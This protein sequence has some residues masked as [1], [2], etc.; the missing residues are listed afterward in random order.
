MLVARFPKDHPTPKENS[1]VL[2]CRHRAK[3]ENHRFVQPA[4]DLWQL[5]SPVPTQRRE[6]FSI[7]LNG[8]RPSESVS[9][10]NSS[11]F[12]FFFPCI[13][14]FSI[15]PYP[16]ILL[17]ILLNSSAG[18]DALHRLLHLLLSPCPS[19]FSLAVHALWG[20]EVAI[21]AETIEIEQY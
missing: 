4:A 21:C 5:R 7:T 12:F 14:F 11:P 18:T 10:F 9:F 19:P 20:K 13:I 1:V 6:K 2:K 3:L 15:F 17:H 16:G 8:S